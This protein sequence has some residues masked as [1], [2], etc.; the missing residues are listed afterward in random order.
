MLTLT[1][2][3][4]DFLPLEQREPQLERL[5]ATI[6][7]CL[8]SGDVFTQYSSSQYL[9]MVLD[10]SA[11]NAGGIGTRIRERFGRGAGGPGLCLQQSVY[12]LHSVGEGTEEN[13][14]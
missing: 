14:G 8:R 12:P 10:T 2:G 11:E 5:R 9:L 7:G 13:P 3:A 1:D 4:G 6:Q